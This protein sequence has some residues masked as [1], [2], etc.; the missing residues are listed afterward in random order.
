MVSENQKI[1]MKAEKHQFFTSF[2]PN[3]NTQIRK[4]VPVKKFKNYPNF[5]I[6]KQTIKNRLDLTGG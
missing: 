3:V 4:S 1:L 6:K 5:Q 2:E